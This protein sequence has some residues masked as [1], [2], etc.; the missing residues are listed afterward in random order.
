MPHTIP[1]IATI[2]ESFDVGIDTR[3]PVDDND[4]QV[5]FRFTGTLDKLTV[6]VGPPQI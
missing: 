6:K 2:D 5:P 3:S 4:Y 1:F